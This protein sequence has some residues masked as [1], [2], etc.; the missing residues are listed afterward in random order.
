MNR[1]TNDDRERVAFRPSTELAVASRGGGLPRC[2]E[3][4]QE[5]GGIDADLSLTM[6]AN[7]F[8]PANLTREKLCA[9]RKIKVAH[10][11]KVGVCARRLTSVASP[12]AG[13]AKN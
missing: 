6:R 13:D 12:H 2:A 9:N 5:R 1:L 7:N 8:H 4:A 3:R 10:Y 11:Q